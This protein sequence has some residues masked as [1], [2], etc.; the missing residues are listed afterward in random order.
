MKSS[1]DTDGVLL[2][3]E[4]R[5]RRTRTRFLTAALA[6]LLILLGL[7][8]SVPTLKY[9]LLSWL[10]TSHARS[11]KPFDWDDVSGL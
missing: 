9:Q 1:N 7:E 3:I 11:N 10:N 8:S 6:T 4:K 5:P 2:D